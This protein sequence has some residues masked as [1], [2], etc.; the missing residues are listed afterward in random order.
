MEREKPLYIGEKITSIYGEDINLKSKHEQMDK[1]RKP[2]HL[3]IYIF[4]W[5]F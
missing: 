1:N 2:N 3:A 4:L 5:Y